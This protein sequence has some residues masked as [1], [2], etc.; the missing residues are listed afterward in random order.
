M[1]RNSTAVIRNIVTLSLLCVLAACSTHLALR[2][3]GLGVEALPISSWGIGERV[4]DG[5]NYVE[6]DYRV[7][8][9][10]IIRLLRRH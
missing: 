7:G 1:I 5:G 2:C 9:V 10:A 8:C 4:T 6:I 3:C